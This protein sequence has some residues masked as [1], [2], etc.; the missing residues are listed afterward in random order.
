MFACYVDRCRGWGLWTNSL[1]FT[2][3]VC[4]QSILSGPNT[5]LLVILLVVGTCGFYGFKLGFHGHVGPCRICRL[6]SDI[7]LVVYIYACIYLYVMVQLILVLQVA[8]VWFCV[9]LFVCSVSDFG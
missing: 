3:F 9:C 4:F 8:V 2:S 5:T 6:S 1:R 7:F